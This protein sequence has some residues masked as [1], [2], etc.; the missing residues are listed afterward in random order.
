MSLELIDELSTADSDE[1]VY[2]ASQSQSGLSQSAKQNHMSL[3]AMSVS[4]VVCF[5]KRNGIPDQYCEKF[6]GCVAA[7]SLILVY[8][9]I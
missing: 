1:Y 6:R 9:Y 4:D 3:D 5:L 7:Y 8:N 2:E